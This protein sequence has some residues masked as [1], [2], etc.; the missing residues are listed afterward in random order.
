MTYD[1][2]VYEFAVRWVDGMQ[3]DQS[4]YNYPNVIHCL[5]QQIQATLEAFERELYRKEV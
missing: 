3:L 5:S 2:K 1:K 4:R